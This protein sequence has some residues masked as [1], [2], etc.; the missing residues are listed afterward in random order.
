MRM[1]FLS[2]QDQAR[3]NQ[4]FMAEAVLIHKYSLGFFFINERFMISGR[5]P[6]LHNWA[7][8]LER[9]KSQGAPLRLFR[10]V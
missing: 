8:Y 2:K 6:K 10:E 9:T 1:G 5:K 4:T 3:I 7:S